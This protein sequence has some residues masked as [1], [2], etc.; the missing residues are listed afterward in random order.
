[1]ERN[2]PFITHLEEGY[3]EETQRGIDILEQLNCLD[4]HDVLVHCLGFSDKDIRK[5]KKA[6]ATIAWC[7]ASN[8]FMFNL[9]CKIRKII[10]AGINVCIGTD[11]T[12]TGSVNLLEE[13]RFARSTYQELYGE[14]LNAK[15]IIQMVT[16]NPANAFRMQ[17]RIGSIEEGKLADLLVLK[18][19]QAD[20]YE[21]LVN[22]RMEDIDLL[23]WEGTPIYGDARY[24][25]LF[26]SREVEYTRIKVRGR[27][28]LV[29]GDPGGL[30]KKV[31]KAVGFKKTLDYMPLDN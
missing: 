12:H 14:D 30:L 25:E 4:N 17:D 23:F 27:E 6:R 20:P 1:M 28:M 24:E 5:A 16:L 19:R 18:P 8:I 22:G 10:R 26:V 11:S 3:D 7:P 13:M 15:G 9:T 21:A 2:F 29:K 31:R